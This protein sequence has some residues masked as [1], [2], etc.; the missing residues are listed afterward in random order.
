MHAK[1]IGTLL[2]NHYIGRPDVLYPDGLTYGGLMEGARLS[3]LY[4]GNWIDSQIMWN[5]CDY[6]L[7]GLGIS[8]DFAARQGWR[9]KV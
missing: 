9:V 6:V 3:V 1:R 2:H 7:A 8:V 5:G 4:N